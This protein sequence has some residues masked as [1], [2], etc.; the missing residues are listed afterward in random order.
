MIQPSTIG[1]AKLSRMKVERPDPA[2]LVSL[3]GELKPTV[4]RRIQMCP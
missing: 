2:T 3:A 1:D 4:S